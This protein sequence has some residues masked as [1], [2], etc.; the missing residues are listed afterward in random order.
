MENAYIAEKSE[1]ELS[2]GSHWAEDVQ[3]YWPDEPG[4]LEV[5]GEATRAWKTAPGTERH[6]F[7]F[8]GQP[9]RG[10]G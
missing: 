8:T 6:G 1:T 2:V 7:F 3:Q 10:T 4:Q 9:D 5:S